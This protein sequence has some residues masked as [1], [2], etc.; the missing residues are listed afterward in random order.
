MRLVHAGLSSLIL[1]L[2]RETAWVGLS[3]TAHLAMVMALFLTMPNGKFVHGFYR[4]V[5]LIADRYEA[6]NGTR[7][8]EGK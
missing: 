2:L 3:L 7:T 5:A 4:I 6:K 1:M 8:G